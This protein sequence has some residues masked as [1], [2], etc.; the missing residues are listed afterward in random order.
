[1][2]FVLSYSFMCL[3]SAVLPFVTEH[4]GLALTMG[5]F[6]ASEESLDLCLL[7]KVHSASAASLPVGLA[8]ASTSLHPS[9]FLVGLMNPVSVSSLQPSYFN[10]SLKQ[11]VVLLLQLPSQCWVELTL[12]QL[13][14]LQEELITCHPWLCVC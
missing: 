13:M 2:F 12:Q 11:T 6:T 3:S 7:L 10:K 9:F 8:A 5:S 4:L 1:M 14:G